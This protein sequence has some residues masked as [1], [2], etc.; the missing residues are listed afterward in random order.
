MTFQFG[1][2]DSLN[3]VI[4]CVCHEVILSSTNVKYLS[5]IIAFKLLK[6]QRKLWY[7]LEIVMR[8]SVR[9]NCTIPCSR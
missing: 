3:V 9:A 5:T 1:D 7:L 8:M 2:N 6:R 4:V